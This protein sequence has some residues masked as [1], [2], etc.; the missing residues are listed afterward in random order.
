MFGGSE[1]ESL[2]SLRMS[3]GEDWPRF[4]MIQMN[5]VTVS[6][7]RIPYYMPFVP[8][9]LSEPKNN[10]SDVHS[11]LLHYSNRTAPKFHCSNISMGRFVRLSN[12]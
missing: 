7:E 11:S 1:R 6:I 8:L 9:V 10:R 12:T 2:P 5:I 3:D 4:D